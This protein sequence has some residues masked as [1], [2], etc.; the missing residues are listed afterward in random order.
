[1]LFHTRLSFAERGIAVRDERCALRAARCAALPQVRPPPPPALSHMA[2]SRTPTTPRCRHSVRQPTLPH[3]ASVR[4]RGAPAGGRG[5]ALEGPL[6]EG[7]VSGVL[8]HCAGTPP[9]VQKVV[10]ELAMG[11]PAAPAETIVSPARQYKQMY[12]QQQEK[13]V[14][15]HAVRI[16]PRLFQRRSSDQTLTQLGWVAYSMR[17]VRAA[18]TRQRVPCFAAAA[19][20]AAAAGL[21]LRTHHPASSSSRRRRQDP[22]LAFRLL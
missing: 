4:S 22:T 8:V 12:R 9:A 1:M 16:P 21:R 13:R 2:A 11:R 15:R 3:T 7:G 5:A 6:F 14:V 18:G 20:A 10:L 17:G 19:R